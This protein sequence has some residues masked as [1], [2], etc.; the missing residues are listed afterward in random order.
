MTIS[1]SHRHPHNSDPGAIHLGYVFSVSPSG[2]RR[3]LH[4]LLPFSQLSLSNPPHSP[5]NFHNSPSIFSHDKHGSG[6]VQERSCRSCWTIALCQPGRLHPWRRI[7][8]D[9]SFERRTWN[10]MSANTAF[11]KGFVVL[12]VS[13]FLHGGGLGGF[14]CLFMIWFFPGLF[15]GYLLNYHNCNYCIDIVLNYLF[16]S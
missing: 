7:L 15:Y 1:F 5:L 11:A 2:P 16:F 14:V 6:Q 4:T 3:R 10:K 12:F 13:L 9:A 8:L